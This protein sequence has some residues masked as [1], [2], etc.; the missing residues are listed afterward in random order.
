[1]SSGQALTWIRVGCGEGF[2]GDPTCLDR[3]L[4]SKFTTCRG[5]QEGSEAPKQPFCPRLTHF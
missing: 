2:T 3:A 4:S 5:L 1:M